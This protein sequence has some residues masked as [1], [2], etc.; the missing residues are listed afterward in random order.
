M[1]KRIT[2]L[3]Y[4]LPQLLLTVLFIIVFQAKIYSQA[5]VKQASTSA[6]VEPNR[7]S[8]DQSGYNVHFYGLDIKV[9]ILRRFISGSVTME[10][11]AQ[12]PLDSISIDLFE[13]YEIQKIAFGGNTLKYRRQ[14]KQIHIYFPEKI[15]Q[16]T[17]TSIQVFYG[18]KPLVAAKAPWDGGF[19]WA[20]DSLKR[21]WVGVACE[22]LGASSWWPCKD[23]LADEPDSAV[24]QFHVPKGLGC[25]SNGQLQN[26]TEYDSFTAYKWK[27]GYPINL[28][29]ITLNIGHYQH[30]TDSFTSVYK[31]NSGR[32]IT[33]PVDYYFLDYN[34]N[35]S[36]AF[37]ADSIYARTK[38]MLHIF[39]KLFGIYPFYRDGFGLV[40]TPYWGMEHQGA[41]AYGNNFRLNAYGFDFILVH[42]TGHEWW[43]NNVSCNDAGDMWIHESFTTYAEALY[44][45]H[46]FGYDSSVTYLK[47]QK[48]N[49][50]NKN[51][52]QGPRNVNFHARDD[53]DIYYKGSWVLHTLRSVLNNDSLWFG[54]LYGMQHEFRYKTIATEDI[55]TY[56][57]KHTGQSLKPFFAQYLYESKLPV[58]QY[59][60]QH[61]KGKS[62]LKYR[63]LG[64]GK[65]FNMPVEII[66]NEKKI[67]LNPKNIFQ[68]YMFDGDVLKSDVKV[69]NGRF[70]VEF[71]N[72]I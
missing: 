43:G 38:T 24:M 11:T 55:I 61:K 53:N 39:E 1:F 44:V 54:M 19:I 6:T 29:N 34:L 35:K 64:A 49:I 13:Q 51:P 4:S 63:W 26:V 31:D 56:F 60:V 16:H 65:N 30:F 70:L 14:D 17:K 9:D 59:W 72:G 37:F 68:L 5:K 57:E 25:I 45:E 32:Q 23:D 2:A 66:V 12:K 21:D 48:P 46:L 20:K 69:D 42:E 58:L 28:Y 22:Q 36:K 50:A 40:E 7:K 27:V 71:R 33:Y 18:G 41:V 15:P 8:A 52:V 3:Q 10:F 67:R 47:M 62:Q